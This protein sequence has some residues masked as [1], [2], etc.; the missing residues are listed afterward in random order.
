M[1][2]FTF[3]QC[4]PLAA[5]IASIAPASAQVTF[6]VDAG[7]RGAK[8]GDLHY[9]IFYEEINHAGDGGLYAEL[10]RNRSFEDASTS[11]SWSKKGSLSWK[12]INAGLLNP[13]QNRALE[14][15]FKAP[16]DAIVNS[17]FW[18]INAVKDQKYSLSFWIKS[19]AGF[20]GT[21]TA[22]LTNAAGD[23]LGS[24]AIPVKAGSEW[25]QITASLTATAADPSARFS[26]ASAKEGT[27][28]LD[29]ISL[30]PPT[31]KNR[32]NGCRID[33]AEKLEAM[34]PAFVRFP[35]GCFIEGTHRDGATNR[36]E[37]KNTIGG[38]ETR[39]GHFNVNWNYRVTDGLG[40][41]ELLQLTEDLGAEP[42]F[43]VNIGLGHG[44][45]V[46]YNEI[47][48]FIQE[49][50]D[51]IEYC[52]GDTSTKWGAVRAA[53][54]HTEPFGLRLIEVGN[55]NYQANVNEQSDHYAERYRQFYD[56]I[57][58]RWPEMLVIGNVE[59]WGTDT[60][61]WRNNHPVDAVDEH[62]YRNPTWFANNYAK[63]DNYDRRGPKVYAGE[64]AV[65]SDFGTTGTLR[66]ALGEAIYMLG[67]ER[68]SDICVMNSYAPI[69]VNENDQCWKPDMIRFGSDYS[70][71]TPSYHVQQLFPNN[72]GSENVRWTE[73]GNSQSNGRRIGFSTWSTTADFDNI[74]VSDTDGNIIFSEDFSSAPAGWTLPAGWS[75]TD[76]VL[77]QTDAS[78]QGLIAAG[79]ND[80]PD[81]FIFEFDATK[82][83]GA[84]GFLVAFN[85][86]GPGDFIWWNIA[87]WANT[88]HAI[89][90]S[91]NGSKSQYDIVRG[92]I[93]T[94]HKYHG[95]IVLANSH[96]RCYLDDQLIHD[97]TLPESK[98]LYVSANID[99]AEGILY[100]K[101]VNMTADA[102]PA[103][104]N[105]SN[106]VPTGVDATLLTAPSSESENS[107]ADPQ[108]V[109]PA[110]GRASVSGNHI[111][112]EAPAN[113]LTILRI[114]VK[115]IVRREGSV[116]NPAAEAEIKAAHASLGR[117]LSMLR[118]DAKLPAST[119]EGYKIS[120]SLGA[121][122]DAALSL[123][124]T[125][126]S[127]QLVA[128]RTQVPEAGKAA[129]TLTGIIT[130]HE[131]NLGTMEFPVTIAPSDDR[132]GYL[133]CYMNSGR[134]ITNYA[135]GSREDKGR[136]FHHLHDGAEI[137]DT[138][139]LAA[140]EHG[141]RD[142]YLNRGQRHDEY[143]ITTTD[144][145]NA[146]SGVWFNYGID[147]LRSSDLVHWDGAAFDFRKGRSIFSDPSATDAAYKSDAEY[148]RVNRVWAPQWIWDASAFNGAGGYLVYYS[149][150]SD[151]DGDT[152][153][154]IMYSYADRDFKTLT[155]PRV[156][157]D[158]GYSV[159]D[160]DIVYNEYDGLYHM[161]LKHEGAGNS[162]RGIWQLTSP[163]LLGQPWTETYHITNEGAELTEGS[164]TV[165]RIDED[166]W[167]IYYM[168]YTGG[169]A[170]KVC[171]T[172]H[173]GKNVSGSSDL[174]G[175]G[176]FQ[177]GSVMTVTQQEY[178]MLRDWDLVVRYLDRARATASP[179]FDTFV[180]KAEGALHRQS[181]SAL[182]DAFTEALAEYDRANAEY[183]KKVV[184]E[185]E[186]GDITSLLANP[187]FNN[188][189]GDG[190][191]GTAFT[192]TSAG[193]A[194]HWNKTFDTY[195]ILESM[196]AGWYM[197]TCSGYY[198]Y[199]GKEAADSH[200]DGSEQILASLYINEAE[201]PFMS[202]YDSSTS[203]TA[204]PYT[205][206]DNVSQ[207]NKAFNSDKY[208]D[209]NW[210][211]VKLEKTGTL[212]LGM[213]KSVLKTNDWT[214]FDN[215]HLYYSTEPLAVTEIEAEDMNAP[216]DVYGIDGILLR[217]DIER[218]QALRELPAGIYIIDGR[219]VVV[220]F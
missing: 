111:A 93:E 133:Y 62:Y 193:V 54:G 115:D 209:R 173:E 31:Y 200:A 50:L 170:Y 130:D 189:N 174:E 83:S 121:D 94:N 122:A 153:D 171:D 53:N 47:G 34:H 20:D 210:V 48:E 99:D 90:M 29:M 160:A 168:R 52:N 60:P 197:L 113:S 82:T 194:E 179:L 114:K 16:G 152:H 183:T 128:D 10:I 156:F 175:T 22:S 141:T 177:H 7:S 182:A 185:A 206:P 125:P 127:S 61:S 205:Y 191:Q 158:P 169:S 32:P 135:L 161:W 180:T 132:Y 75:V 120:W 208:Y 19:P 96:L 89:E 26:L 1:K 212:R 43:V 213:R 49:A 97:I 165:R 151:N 124:S 101:A 28:D 2:L 45:S 66:A 163:A 27:V 5:L 178:T 109:Y 143:F 104:I 71:G 69:F 201:A 148:A 15:S 79:P 192:A 181:V 198:R 154:R 188:N 195:Q 63:Y 76:G 136:R 103:T 91:V 219:K 155:Q 21:L 159:I 217:H 72:H 164:S 215:F 41:H 118:S 134:E 86:G 110:A 4:V 17:G 187:D 36:F 166:D 162:E 186:D 13:A 123:V 106:G 147:L 14:V 131:G 107:K 92:S 42:L 23:D 77:R 84:E 149:M 218:G 203:Y 33:L 204:S 57:K 30:F 220:G 112:F 119:P 146:N 9:G 87:G 6:D 35:G 157:Y 102:I 81:N 139:A 56:A 142:A 117:R 39:P 207:A 108:N 3:L 199:G 116:M 95:K 40:F 216:V 150:L 138:H 58:A 172:D 126:W 59:A 64:Y 80:T 38:I 202:L 44:W 37:W 196:P 88:Q 140:I 73:H 85:Y 25:K 68:N 70:F 78:S 55:E 11:E 8:I 105:L 100:L 137:F 12:I 129:G 24:V 144:M 67:M 184:T 98:K 211:S 65:T 214:C 18:G 46:P 145:S 74:R 167:N 51:A 176:A 190:W